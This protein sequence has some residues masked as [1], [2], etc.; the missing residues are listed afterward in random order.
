[1]KQPIRARQFL[2]QNLERP[3]AATSGLS[4][5]QCTSSKNYVLLD[6]CLTS[7]LDTSPLHTPTAKAAD[8]V[9]SP[10]LELLLKSHIHTTDFFRS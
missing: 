8:I 3:I 5:P 9:S 2:S 7:L 1:M 4:Y 10:N 6:S